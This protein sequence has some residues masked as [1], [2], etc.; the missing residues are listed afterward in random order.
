MQ[1]LKFWLFYKFTFLLALNNNYD[2]E[3]GFFKTEMD[4]KLGEQKNQRPDCLKTLIKLFIACLLLLGGPFHI[5]NFHCPRR[6]VF[7][8]LNNPD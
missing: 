7:A 3:V 2:S 1:T 5:K 4:K 8:I 6:P